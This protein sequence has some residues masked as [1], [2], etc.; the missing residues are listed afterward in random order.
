MAGKREGSEVIL[1][2]EGT[3]V[4]RYL[5]DMPAG[6][7]VEQIATGRRRF[8]RFGRGKAL[9]A[10]QAGDLVY[11]QI[12]ERQLLSLVG[13]PGTNKQPKLSTPRGSTGL[14]TRQHE[15]LDGLVRGQTLAEIAFHLGI[16]IRSVRHHVDALK[17]KFGAVSLS[18]LA[19]K[20]LA[21]GW[22]VSTPPQGGP[23]AGQVSE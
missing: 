1:I 12:G 8:R 5:I 7:L 18:Q 4:T 14:T 10:W 15:V 23:G 20:A 2:C 9:S 11:V 21:A 16:R 6:M 3:I 22:V 13:K 17:L 19:A